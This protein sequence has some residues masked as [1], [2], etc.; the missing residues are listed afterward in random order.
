[1]AMTTNTAVTEKELL[2]L[3]SNADTD[4]RNANAAYNRAWNA[5]KFRSCPKLAR[6]AD[7]YWEA[8][9]AQDQAITSLNSFRR[10]ESEKKRTLEVWRHD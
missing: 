7:R 2:C 1:M 8:K 4:F 9:T 3:V 10:Q 5:A 6:A